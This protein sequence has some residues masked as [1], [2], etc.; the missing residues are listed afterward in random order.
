[1]QT[2]TPRANLCLKAHLLRPTPFGRS[3]GRV[4]SQAELAIAPALSLGAAAFA[5]TFRSLAGGPKYLH[6]VAGSAGVLR[7]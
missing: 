6:A 1:M 4:D 7:C 5:N 2:C 3:S